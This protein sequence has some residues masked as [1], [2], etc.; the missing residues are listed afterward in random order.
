MAALPV[1]GV[2]S[3]APFNPSSMYTMKLT[4][5]GTGK[6]VESHIVALLKSEPRSG[7]PDSLTGP[8]ARTDS[9]TANTKCDIVLAPGWIV[10]NL[11]AFDGGVG[12]GSVNTLGF[13]LFNTGSVQW[14]Q[15]LAYGEVQVFGQGYIGLPGWC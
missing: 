5:L 10:R 8:T 6:V 9:S 14:S 1:R 11:L 3:G 4:D 15:P 7:G 13:E 2:S 12:A